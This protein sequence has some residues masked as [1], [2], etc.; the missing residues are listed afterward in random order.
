LTNLDPDHPWFKEKG[1]TPETVK[2][3]GLG[4]C[5]K[6]LMAGRIAIPIHDKH[7]SLVAYCGRAVTEEQ[8]VEEGKYKLPPEERFKKSWE[9]YNLWRHSDSW[10]KTVLL[11]SFISVWWLCQTGIENVAALMGSSLSDRQAELLLEVLGPDGRLALMMDADE[12]GERCVDECYEK[13]GSRLYI[14]NIQIGMIAK[15]PHRL[16]P[17]DIRILLAG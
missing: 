3:F 16:R 13:L 8:A 5:S 6:G 1:I 11:E 15:K 14:R 7:G 17:D 12:S 9:V 2:Y 4:F 10:R